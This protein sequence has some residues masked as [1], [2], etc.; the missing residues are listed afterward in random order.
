M[1]HGWKRRH[2]PSRIEFRRNATCTCRRIFDIHDAKAFRR[3]RRC[4]YQILV[5]T[6]VHETDVRLSGQECI[7]N[8][9]HIVAVCFADKEC[10]GEEGSFS[11]ELTEHLTNADLIALKAFRRQRHQPLSLEILQT[12]QIRPFLLHQESRSRGFVRIRHSRRN[13]GS[14]HAKSVS[15]HTTKETRPSEDQVDISKSDCF[16]ELPHFVQPKL[17]GAIQRLAYGKSRRAKMLDGCTR[18]TDKRRSDAQQTSGGLRSDFLSNP[19]GNRKHNAE[20]REHRQELTSRHPYSPYE[21]SNHGIFH[22]VFVSS[23]KASCLRMNAPFLD[24]MSQASFRA[25]FL[26]A[27]S[28]Q[29]RFS[30]RSLFAVESE[31]HIR[32]GL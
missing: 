8:L 15:F 5:K 19:Q 18:V 11:R 24:G 30:P 29:D 23:A 9:G 20:R 7:H 21:A 32:S 14:Q 28:G 27:L 16:F 6:C 22:T 10:F 17:Y 31:H 12:L 2:G 13:F 25:Q 4:P 1:V 26:F 3:V